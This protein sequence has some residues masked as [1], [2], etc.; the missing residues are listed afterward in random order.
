MLHILRCSQYSYYVHKVLMS[1]TQVKP[2]NHKHEQL[3][4]RH[5]TLSEKHYF[6]KLCH[7]GPLSFDTLT[8]KTHKTIF[9]T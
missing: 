4:D 7:L 5:L 2:N 1:T 8:H 6:T 3:K 9:G